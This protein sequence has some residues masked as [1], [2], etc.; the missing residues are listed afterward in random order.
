MSEII[1]LSKKGITP[2]EKRAK[3]KVTK[4]EI[5]KIKKLEE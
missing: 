3:T 2:Q 4:G 5:K 1:K